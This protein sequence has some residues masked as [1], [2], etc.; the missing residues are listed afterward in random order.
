[1][2]QKD[3][4]IDDDNLLASTQDRNTALSDLQRDLFEQLI[5]RLARI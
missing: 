2:Q 1:M 5:R 4:E 3:F